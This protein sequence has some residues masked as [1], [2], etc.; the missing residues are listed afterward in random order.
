MLVIKELTC[1]CRRHKRQEFDPWVR[2][3]PWRR[4]WQ[5][6]P[7]FL[8]GKSPRTE[9]PGGLQSRGSPRVGH[10]WSD[11]PCMHIYV[12]N[13]ILFSHEKVRNPAIC[14]NIDG[15]W[16]H[17][18]KWNKTKKDKY[19]TVLL[20]CGIWMIK[21]QT[22]KKK[23]RRVVVRGWGWGNRERQ[24]G[25]NFQLSRWISCEDLM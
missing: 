8:P 3:I 18:A 14:D 17:A 19:H 23:S 20:I 15:L 24:K 13:G 10:D 22:H 5:S 7:V 1:Q 16:Q 4:G 25:T 2:K 11:L 9:E 12:Y 21:S 6:T